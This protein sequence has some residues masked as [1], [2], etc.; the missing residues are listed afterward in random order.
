MKVFV[1]RHLT[2][3]RT[4]ALRILGGAPLTF[5]DFRERMWGSM[6]PNGFAKYF[7][8]RMVYLG[9]VQ[10]SSAKADPYKLTEEG[11][12]LLA[13]QP[14]VCAYCKESHYSNEPHQRG[15]VVG[16]SQAQCRKCGGSHWHCARCLKDWSIVMGE[17]PRYQRGLRECP[18]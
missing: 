7:L 16:L 8:D 1:R 13:Q 10:P 2:E 5:W 12:G 15:Q 3:A 9:L 6:M 18:K 17:F 4:K 14:W 11:K